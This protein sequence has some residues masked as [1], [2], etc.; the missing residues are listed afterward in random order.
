[1]VKTTIKKY[2]DFVTYFTKSECPAEGCEGNLKKSK[3][4]LVCKKCPARYCTECYWKVYIVDRN[5]G[6]AIYKCLNKECRLRY[7]PIDA[8]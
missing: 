7:N 1:M 2:S 8:K 4:M 3:E 6:F 5:W